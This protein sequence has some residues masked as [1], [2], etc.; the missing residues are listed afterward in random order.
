M[1]GSY[2]R[3]LRE[4]VAFAGITRNARADHVLPRC[5]SSAIA[6]NDVV[7]IQIRAIKNMPAVLAGVLVAFENIVTGEL[8]FLFRKAI[9]KEQ[10]DHAR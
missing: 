7:E 2:V 5:H 10:H 1:G 8:H 9:K 3:F 4:P 6:R